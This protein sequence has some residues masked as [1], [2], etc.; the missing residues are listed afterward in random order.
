MQGLVAAGCGVA[1]LPAS[2][3]E[4]LHPDL[5]VRPLEPAP[6]PR[7]V[8]AVHNHPSAVAGPR[9]ALL[10]ALERAGGDAARR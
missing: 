4:V 10:A 3:V 1:L 6:A 2:A 9:D 5:V 8:A 7:V